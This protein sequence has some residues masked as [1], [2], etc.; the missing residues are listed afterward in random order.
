LCENSPRN[1]VGLS[2]P[3]GWVLGLE[4]MFFSPLYPIIPH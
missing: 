1:I 4:H 3:P 2:P